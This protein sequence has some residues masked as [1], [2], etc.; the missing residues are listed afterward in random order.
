[1]MDHVRRGYGQAVMT[2]T[3]RESGVLSKFTQTADGGAVEATESVRVENDVVEL[4]GDELA[5][6]QRTFV[7]RG[8]GVVVQSEFEE[9]TDDQPDC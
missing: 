3:N 8:D 4:S 9:E 1:M 5:Q 6:T 2:G 7:E